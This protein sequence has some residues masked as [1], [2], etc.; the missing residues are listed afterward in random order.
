MFAKADCAFSCV[1]RRVDAVAGQDNYVGR[2]LFDARRKLFVVLSV[3][4]VVQVGDLYYAYFVV[5]FKTA[6]AVKSFGEISV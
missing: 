5:G 6:D 3:E 1:V 2:K 4:T